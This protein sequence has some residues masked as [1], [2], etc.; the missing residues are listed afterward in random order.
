[1][2][3]STKYLGGHTDVMGGVLVA[4]EDDA[5]FGRIRSIQQTAGGIP[6]PF[7]S[8]L[9]RRGLRT[10]AW[11]V[12]AQTSNA[13]AVTTFLASHPRVSVVHYPG[14]ALHPGHDVAARQMPL[15]GAMASFEV[16]GA[17]AEAM[18]VANRCRLFTRATSLGGAESL[19][20]HRASI[21]GPTTRAPESL[22]RISVGLEHSDDLIEDLNQALA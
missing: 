20:E 13:A 5:F 2:H 3:A 16:V 6:S 18:A 8:W 7:D 12:R 10:L 22:L 1:M 15:F 4:R 14:L 19:I 9:V 21:E 17:R 11:R